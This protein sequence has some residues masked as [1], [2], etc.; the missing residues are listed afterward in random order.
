MKKLHKRSV[1]GA[2]RVP[3]SASP[4][5]RE[6]TEHRWADLLVRAVNEQGIVSAAYSAF[7]SYSLGNQLAALLQCQS[8]NL[9]PSPIATYAGWQSLSRQVRKGQKA[10]TLCQPV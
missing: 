9:Q 3:A 10:L 6:A 1:A 5:S 8:R 4:S 2:G 7:W